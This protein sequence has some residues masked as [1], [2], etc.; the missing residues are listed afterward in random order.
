MFIKTMNTNLKIN[1]LCSLGIELTNKFYSTNNLNSMS[2]VI[3]H[4]YLRFDLFFRQM[5]D[6][7]FLRNSS[8]T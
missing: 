3:G 8:S 4:I 6:P 1:L 7:I 2:T 5:M